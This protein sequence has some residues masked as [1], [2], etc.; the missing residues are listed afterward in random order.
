MNLYLILFDSAPYFKPFQDLA[1]ERNFHAFGQIS[2]CFTTTSVI[3]LL[4]GKMPSDLEEGGIGYESEFAAGFPA[5]GKWPWENE[6]LLSLLEEEG[7]AVEIHTDNPFFHDVI[8]QRFTIKYGDIHSQDYIKGIQK[9]DGK[10]KISFI[11]YNTYHDAIG[12]KV[13]YQE[14]QDATN[15]CLSYWDFNQQDSLFWLFADHG[16]FSKIT[17]HI[18]PVGFMTWAL[19]KD[20]TA[21]PIIP[22]TDLISIRDFY[23]TVLEKLRI[24]INDPIIKAESKSVTSPLD[25]DRVFF[26][27]DSRSFIDVHNSTAFS[28]VTIDSWKGLL[29]DYT[30]SQATVF[31]HMNQDLTTHG[32][33]DKSSQLR[34]LLNK[35]FKL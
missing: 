35:R 27:E 12:G 32:C 4:T 10:N 24:K 13:S 21:D 25:L 29:E 26:I 9:T 17:H 28:A 6:L 30:Y 20:N 8:S 11:L 14:A 18:D 19:M 2:N 1:G 5:S 3:S 33:P 23:R 15:K 7:W 16:D 22:H 31:K 34:D